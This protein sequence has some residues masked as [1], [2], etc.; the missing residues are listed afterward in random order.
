V[1]AYRACRAGVYS[2]GPGKAHASIGH[3]PVLRQARGFRSLLLGLALI[4]GVLAMHG[5]QSSS[6]PSDSSGLPAAVSTERIPMHLSVG[7]EE[8]GHRTQQGDGNH[9]HDR[10]AGGEICL[11]LLALAGFAVLLRVVRRAWRPAILLPR[12]G[13]RTRPRRSGRSPPPPTFRTDVLRL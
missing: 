3:W 1:F 11:A 6:G 9:D 7:A 13:S 10:H 5:L 12:N 2:A 8:S 4:C